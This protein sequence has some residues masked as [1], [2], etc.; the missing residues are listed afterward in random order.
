MKSFRSINFEIGKCLAEINEFGQLL[1]NNN[2]LS[3]KKDILPFFEKRDHLSAFLAN[4][5]Q[6]NSHYDQ[7]A[8]ELSLF[9]DFTCDLAA[10]DKANNAYCMIEF[11]D[12]TETSIFRSTARSRPDWSTRYE[13]GFSQLVDWMWKID[14]QKPTK[15]FHNLFGSATIS[16]V[17]MLVVGRSSFVAGLERDRY[18]WRRNAV[19]I[20]G[21]PV[22]CLTYDDLY[23][24]LQRKLSFAAVLSKQGSASSLVPVTGSN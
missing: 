8:H 12:A 5:N 22:I 3:E 24:T 7:V 9:G 14:D 15:A 16:I 2:T 11:E 1:Q 21:T 6:D 23:D 20:H 19:S 10:G 18:K 4:F 13:H 17:P